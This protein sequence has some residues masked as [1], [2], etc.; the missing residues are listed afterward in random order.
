M[1]DEKQIP[2][3]CAPRDDNHA[4]RS[5]L[6]ALRSTLHA[7]RPMTDTIIRPATRAD[8]ATI[9][10][11]GALLVRTHY[12]FDPKRFIPVTPETASRYGGFLGTQLGERDVCVLVAEREGTVIGYTYAGVEEYDYMALRG[13]AG[14]IYD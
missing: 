7:P 3:R 6:R 11:L 14:V 10:K 8:L 4:P 12:E 5:M 2:R 13:P 9:G 1:H